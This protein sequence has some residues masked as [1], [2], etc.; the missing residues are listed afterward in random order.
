MS[1]TK[2]SGTT[3]SGIG[4]VRRPERM[5]GTVSYTMHVGPNGRA[6]LVKCDPRPMARAGDLVRLTLEDGRVLTCQILD[7]SSYCAVVSD[8]RGQ[9]A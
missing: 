1:H 9:N 3:L 4:V 5:I 2:P 6:S 7:S 8:E